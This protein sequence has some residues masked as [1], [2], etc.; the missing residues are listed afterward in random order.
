MAG[1]EIGFNSLPGFAIE[2]QRWR[3]IRAYKERT[4]IKKFKITR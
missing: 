3:A 4:K 1:I 2:T